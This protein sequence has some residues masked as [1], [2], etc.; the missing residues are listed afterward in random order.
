MHIKI[1]LN[2]VRKNKKTFFEMIK[3]NLQMF[4]FY[5]FWIGLAGYAINMKYVEE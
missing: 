4:E 2:G 5:F 3:P 1:Y